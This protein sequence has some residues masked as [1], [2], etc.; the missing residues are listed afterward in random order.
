MHHKHGKII[1]E[2][3]DSSKTKTRVVKNSTSPIFEDTINLLLLENEESIDASIVIKVKNVHKG[4]KHTLGIFTL[5]VNDIILDKTGY[6]VKQIALSPSRSDSLLTFRAV[7][8][9]PTINF[10]IFKQ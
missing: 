2:T 7:W 5:D 6:L 9:R 4:K 1:S 3:D 8:S 10:N